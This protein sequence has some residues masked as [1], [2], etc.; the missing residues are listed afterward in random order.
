MANYGIAI[1]INHYTH[2]SNKGL[3]ELGGQ[4]RTLLTCMHF[5]DDPSLKNLQSD[6]PKI[7]YSD[8]KLHSLILAKAVARKMEGNVCNALDVG[9]IPTKMGRQGAPDHLTQSFQ[10]Q[11][12]L[13]V[14]ISSFAYDKLVRIPITSFVDVSHQYLPTVQ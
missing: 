13:A 12:W 5:G 10:T 4:S 7:T 11:V 8:S 1:G 3:K 14:N 2:P 9:W 6:Q